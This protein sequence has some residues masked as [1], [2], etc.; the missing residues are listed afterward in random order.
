ME[1]LTKFQIDILKQEIK[2]QL[3]N[4][5]LN[6][7]IYP[8]K[9]GYYWAYLDLSRY[10]GYELDNFGYQGK[11]IPEAVNGLMDAIEKVKAF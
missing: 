10:N 5:T 9:K 2:Y 3:E 11:T 4:D 8:Y 6:I 1:N 7:V